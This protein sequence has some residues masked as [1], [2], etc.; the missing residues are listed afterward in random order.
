[1]VFKKLAVVLQGCMLTFARS[2]LWNYMC[3]RNKKATEGIL[4]KCG[5]G[6]EMKA[7][8]HTQLTQIKLFLRELPAINCHWV[9]AYY[10]ASICTWAVLV[11]ICLHIFLEFTT[12][13]LLFL[14]SLHVYR[15]SF[16]LNLPCWSSQHPCIAEM[17]S[18]IQS[19]SCCCFP[20]IPNF[21][22]QLTIPFSINYIPSCF[23]PALLI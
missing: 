18:S 11:I 21:E 4:P 13:L 17:L 2:Q 3:I 8:A 9:K 16:L 1:M 12:M 19:L 15:H 6:W 5:N 20:S 14:F 22:S 23:A 7:M 10:S